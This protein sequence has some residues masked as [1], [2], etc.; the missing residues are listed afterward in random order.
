M[1]KNIWNNPIDKLLTDKSS[2][3]RTGLQLKN[4][5]NPGNLTEFITNDGS[6]NIKWYIC[7]PTVY[8]DSH[9]G[10][11]RTY[12]SFDI[13][14]RIMENYF[15]YNIYYTMNITDIDDKIIK[16]VVDQKVE[17]SE[18][19]RKYENLFFEDMKKL[20]VK[21]PNQITRVTEF[22]PEIIA[23]IE[24]L[25][26]NGYAY[27]SNG[28]VYFDINSYTSKGHVYAKLDPSKI[29][30]TSAAEVDGEL[31]A[32]NVSDKRNK[33]DFALWKKGKDGEPKWT[34]PWGEGRPGWH[35]ECSV[36]SS[37]VFGENLDI[38]SGGCDLKFPH[39]DNEIAQTEGYYDHSQWI[40]YFLHTGHLH[41]NGRKMSKSEKNFIK[42]I[43]I[44]EQGYS[45]NSIRIQ[46]LKHK[47]DTEMDYNIDGL[48]SAREDDKKFSDFFFN[49]KQILKV[50]NT[51]TDMKF[52][53]VDNDLMSYFK[54]IQ[55]DI[56]KCLCNNIDTEGA[57][58]LVKELMNAYYVYER[59]AKGPAYKVQLGYG[60]GNY[61]AYIFKAFGL[62]YSSKF[63]ESFTYEDDTEKVLKPYAESF[64]QFRDKIRLLAQS[65][66]IKGLFDECDKL[67]DEV[68]PNLGIKLRD[69]PNQPSV[70]DFCDKDV[71]LKEI[72]LEK[73]LKKDKEDAKRKEKEEKE[74]KVSKI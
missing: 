72:E 59:N 69:I 46:F 8:D 53:Q 30:E 37:S 68:L 26:S 62:D 36:M 17:L 5:L 54:K 61:I 6:N 45:A 40:N 64:I 67:R 73:K 74:L 66:D 1:E 10:H 14:R 56:H 3:F 11:A 24:K 29:T 47:W 27:E 71:L 22:I 48:N 31:G 19:T 23:F 15:G 65:K 20:N 58:N 57:L 12:L 13:I 52:N 49:L 21:Y 43:D 38:H 63:L 44:L 18:V 42:I 55:N 41:I 51:K 25:I 60:V 50:A 28:S 16:K 34:S 39:H 35:I 9:L 33:N 32:Q 2:I 70:W 7:G 4:S